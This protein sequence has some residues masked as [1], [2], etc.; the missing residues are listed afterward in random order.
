MTVSVQLSD[1]TSRTD[2]AQLDEI[3]REFSDD[4]RAELERTFPGT[5]ID[6]VPGH[7]APR[8]DAD[9]EAERQDAVESIGSA[10]NRVMGRGGRWQ[11]LLLPLAERPHPVRVD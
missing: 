1:I 4:F 7:F 9:S 11:M 5:L 2:V 6:V 8:V 3:I 10:Y